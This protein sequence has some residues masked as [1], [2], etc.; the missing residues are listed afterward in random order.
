MIREVEISSCC[1]IVS[2]STPS[3]AVPDYWD[4]E[5]NWFTPKDLSSLVGKYIDESP[6]KITEQGYKS[7]STNLLPPFSLMLSSRAPIGHLAINTVPASTNQGFKSLIPKN[8]ID[9]NYLY[10][11]IKRIVP[12]LQDLGNGATFKELSKSTLSKVK[13]PLPPLETQKKIAEKLDAADTLRQKTK[14]LI[15]KYDQ[16][17]QSLFL[18]MFGDPVSNS[19]RWEK[20]QLKE[21]CHKITDGTHHSPEAQKNGYPYVTAKHVKTYGLDFYSN[22]TYVS[23]EAHDDIYKRCNPEYGDVLYIK[24][25]ATTGI[26]CINTF[27]DP[28]SLLSSLALIKPDNSRINNYYLCYWL[29][30]NGVKEKLIN[31][32]MAGAAIRRYTLKKIN[33][34]KINVP[35]LPLQNQF[36]ERVQAVE[37]QKA[38]ARESLE[39]SE[40][41]FQSL[42]QKAFRGEIN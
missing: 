6:E 13:I 35:P 26:A 5:I 21:I 38:K 30:H 2:G 42:L 1:E 8:N 20:Q 9:V 40:E 24:D 19:N 4:G 3:R 36:A 32:F 41:L 31:E 27:S 7:C 11:A 22:P 15:E 18:D 12:M 17:T 33:I 28:I 34:F 39:K 25:G 37:E 10:Y 16:L 14:T 29:N 23:K